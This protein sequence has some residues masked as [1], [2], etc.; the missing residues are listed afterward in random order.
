VAI[1]SMTA[2]SLSAV[3]QDGSET[4]VRTMLV[5]VPKT[6]ARGGQ[7]HSGASEG[8]ALRDTELLTRCG[9]VIRSVLAGL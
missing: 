3:P 9:G 8:G 2:R 4:A 1:S 6:A 5:P 7:P